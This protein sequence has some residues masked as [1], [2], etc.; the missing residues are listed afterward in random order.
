ME[1]SR[2]QRVVIKF[3]KAGKTASESVEMVCAACGDAALIQ[4]KFLAVM[5]CFVKGW[6]MF[7]TTPEV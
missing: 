2:E 7:K 6:K 3:F 5:Y 1:S 4:S